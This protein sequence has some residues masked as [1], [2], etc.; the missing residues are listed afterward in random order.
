MFASNTQYSP[1][2][3]VSSPRQKGQT[4]SPERTSRRC[5]SSTGS[6]QRLHRGSS[7]RRS[8]A[9][10]SEISVVRIPSMGGP[11]RRIKRNHS[12]HPGWC[13]S[14]RVRERDPAS[15]V[16]SGLPGRGRAPA[17]GVSPPRRRPRTS[18]RCRWVSIRGGRG[19][20]GERRR[21]ASRAGRPRQG[22]DG[23]G[24][25]RLNT[26]IRW[27]SAP[28]VLPRRGLGGD[29]PLATHLY[30]SGRVAGH[31][32]ES[33]KP[34]NHAGLRADFLHR[35][36]TLLAGDLTRVGLFNVVHRCPPRPQRPGNPE[37]VV[38]PPDCCL[39]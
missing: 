38:A 26:S 14:S 33:V 13:P 9:R 6:W 30:S 29:T 34:G 3:S 17:A 11:L 35:I 5:S 31:T 12:S 23:A 25:S 32:P 10:V 39:S 4:Y 2:H 16:Q 18:G 21:S 36:S 22:W 1:G 8:A 19:V 15:A 24:Y 37:P 7:A 20:L 28:M 27:G